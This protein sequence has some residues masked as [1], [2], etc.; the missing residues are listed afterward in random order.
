MGRSR[1]RGRR[2]R[3]RRFRPRVPALTTLNYTTA[4]AGSQTTLARKDFQVLAGC[5][6]RSFKIVGLKLTVAALSE[7]VIIQVHVFNPGGQEIGLNNTLIADTRTNLNLRIPS[8]FKEWWQGETALST[9]LVRVDLLRT[10]DGQKAKVTFLLS[11]L[12]RL[13]SPE[14]TGRS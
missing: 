6:D 5:G 12:V 1:N 11:C 7:P 8:S 4:S 10:Y 2:R 3:V 14:L 9:T 13:G